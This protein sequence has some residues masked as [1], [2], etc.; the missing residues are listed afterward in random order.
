MKTISSVSAIAVLAA[1]GLG[2]AVAQDTG[3]STGTMQPQIETNTDTTPPATTTT[4]EMTTPAPTTGT[5]DTGTMGDTAAM[6]TTSTTPQFVEMQMDGQWLASDLMGAEIRGSG[7]EEIGDVSDVLIGDDGSP[8]AVVIGVGGFLG[9]GEKNVAVPFDRLTVNTEADDVDDVR[10]VLETTKE[11]LEGAPA[12]RSLE[13]ANAQADASGT[14]EGV[15]PSTGATGGMT[16]G[17]DTSTPP[18]QP[19]Q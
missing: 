15:T 5:S 2:T 3:T 19:Q 16:G 13:D 8:S 11:E 18:A 14:T 12:F 7:D 4:P 9:I 6:P 1:F 17:A 10:I